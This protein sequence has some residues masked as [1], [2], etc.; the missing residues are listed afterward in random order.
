MTQTIINISL[1]AIGALVMLVSII[2]TLSFRRYLRVLRP[3]SRSSISLYFTICQALMV[4]FLVGYLGAIAAI[5][6]NP[7]MLW[8]LSALIMTKF[9]VDF[10]FL[11][12]VLNFCKLRLNVFT[13]LICEL[14]YPFYVILF[15]VIV[16]FGNFTWKG[17]KCN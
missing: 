9:V 7:T 1:I 2:Q 8:Y 4:F 6:I 15:G 5:L 12:K 11:K 13:F 14:L 16:H 3:D 17:R 10:I